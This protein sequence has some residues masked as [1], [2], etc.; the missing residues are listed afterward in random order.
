MNDTTTT[1]PERLR[2]YMPAATPDAVPLH[3]A[4]LDMAFATGPGATRFAV[5]CIQIESHKG[6]TYRASA[7]N[8]NILICCEYPRFADEPTGKWLIQ[9][10]SIKSVKMPG[11]AS[12]KRGAYFTQA[13]NLPE[14]LHAWAWVAAT[15]GY[16]TSTFS[17]ETMDATFPAI[18]SVIPIMND[19]GKD[20]ELVPNMG[21]SVIGIEAIGLAKVLSWMGKHRCEYLKDT[22]WRH[23]QANKPITID[24]HGGDGMRMFAVV[25]PCSLS[26]TD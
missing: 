10:E 3:P 25:M 9:G 14:N 2:P 1:T 12:H 7:T 5:S 20:Q 11:K 4:V 17:A 23:R 13:D 24:T 6:D 26:A 18:D 19:N 16:Q 21:A 15:R 22:Q 8:G